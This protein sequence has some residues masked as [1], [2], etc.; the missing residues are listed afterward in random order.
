VIQDPSKYFG[1]LGSLN[2]H[3]WLNTDKVWIVNGFMNKADGN[4]INAFSYKEIGN[5]NVFIGSYPN[6]EMDL[7]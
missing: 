6:N 1:Q 4:F 5:T 7:A 2:N 3:L